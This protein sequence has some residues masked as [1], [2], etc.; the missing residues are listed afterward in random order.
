[1]SKKI[2]MRSVSF[3]GRDFGKPKAKAQDHIIHCVFSAA[4]V[5]HTFPHNLGKVPSRYVEG[6]KRRDATLGPPG[7]VYDIYPFATRTHVTLYCDASG[8]QAEIVLT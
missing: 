7:K 2:V 8:T 6:P 5:P 3:S 1:M 4:N